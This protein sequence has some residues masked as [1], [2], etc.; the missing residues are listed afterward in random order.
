MIRRAVSQ[1]ITPLAGKRQVRAAFSTAT[2]DRMGDQVVQAGIDLSSYRQNPVILFSHDPASPVARCVT[3]GLDGGNLAGLVQF[4]DAGVSPLSDQILGLI[5]AGIINATSIGFAVTESQPLNPG[6][7]Y[8]GTKFTKTVLYEISFVS[9]PANA[10]A[11]VT[12]RSA[13]RLP[14]GPAAALRVGAVAAR[15][16]RAREVEVLR[17]AEPPL[18]AIERREREWSRLAGKV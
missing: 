12:E 14:S 11:L 13:A 4:P 10:S 7:P 6:K 15:A 8:A 1:A 3:I 16:H 5:Q 17:L 9:I 18:S 2:T